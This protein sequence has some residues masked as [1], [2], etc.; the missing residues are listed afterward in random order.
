MKVNHSIGSIAFLFATPLV[1]GLSV[2]IAPSSAA[3]IAGS[4]A[5]VAIYN[6]S[7]RPINTFKSCDIC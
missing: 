6:F 2:G 5:E 1:T 4:A 3:I 7:D